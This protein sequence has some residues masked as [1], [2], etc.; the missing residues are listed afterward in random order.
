[1]RAPR[2]TTAPPRPP[3]SPDGRGG[4][5]PCGRARRRGRSSGFSPR[6]VGVPGGALALDLGVGRGVDVVEDLREV[7]GGV[8]AG[9]GAHRR[10][11]L[12]PLRLDAGEELRLD[13]VGLQQG[14]EAGD[15][16]AR[17]PVRLLLAGAVAGGVVRGGVRAHAVGL[18]LDVERSVTCGDVVEGV[19]R[20]GVAGDDVV[21]VHPQVR[22]AEAV[23]TVRQGEPRL[24]LA[25]HRDRPVVVLQEEQHRSLRRGGED[26]RLV[27]VALGG[28]AVVVYF[29]DGATSQG[30]A[31]EALVFASSAEAPVLFFLQNNHWAIS[32]P[33]ERQSRFPL[34]NRAD[35][36][37][38]PHLRVDGNDVVACYAATR[39]AIDH[40]AAGHG[41]FYIEAETYRMGAHTTSDDPTRYRTREEEAH[42][43]ARDPIARLR[44][45]L[46]ADGVEPEFFAGVEAEG[47]ELGASVRA[48]TRANTAGDFTE[49]FDHVYASPNAQVERERAAWDAYLSRGESR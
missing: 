30:D 25:G 10:P 37:G 9:E 44:A 4:R 32:V 20:G 48:F 31:N 1:M 26:E 40:I 16:V 11:Q 13:A 19:A 36:F 43:L 6:E 17:Q 41:P 45:L 12:A 22:D 3:S 28:G 38:I 42:W 24:A 27:G 5:D 14:A 8:R 2:P 21:P 23:R 46:E 49:V 47:R 34:A 35:G 29:G 7:P 15:R 33:T 39:Y 18:G